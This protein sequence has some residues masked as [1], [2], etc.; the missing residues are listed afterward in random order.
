MKSFIVSL[1]LVFCAF[2]A[3]AAD[4]AGDGKMGA[5]KS[6]FEKLCPGVQPGDGH[7][8]ACFKEHKDK[9]SSECKKELAAQRKSH[10]AA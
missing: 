4:A 8:K 7:V 6:D 1:S 10:K 5:C 3:M 9:L 2:G